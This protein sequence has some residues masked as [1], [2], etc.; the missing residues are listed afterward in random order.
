MVVVNVALAEL[1]IITA[2]HV[3]LKATINIFIKA[4]MVPI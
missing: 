2:N 3:F 4:A 1:C